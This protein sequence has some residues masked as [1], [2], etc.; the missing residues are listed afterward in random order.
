[1]STAVDMRSSLS[2]IVLDPLAGEAAMM[3]HE[4]ARRTVAGRRIWRTRAVLIGML[5]GCVGVICVS[6]HG[7]PRYPNG[8]DIAT[9]FFSWTSG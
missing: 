6:S 3:A 5:A 8:A 7:V 4:C 2:V 1:M 9:N